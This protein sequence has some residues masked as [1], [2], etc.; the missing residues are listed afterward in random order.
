MR[1]MAKRQALFCNVTVR[2]IIKL[3]GIRDVSLK[4]CEHKYF[5]FFAKKAVANKFELLVDS[6]IFLELMVDSPSFLI[7][8]FI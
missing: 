6:V 4:K 5:S 7:F 8:K 2:K 3:Q 1:K